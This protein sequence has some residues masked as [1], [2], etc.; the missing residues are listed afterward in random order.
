M[1]HSPSF[2]G[3]LGGVLLAGKAD[4]VNNED[5]LVG[6]DPV[7]DNPIQGCSIGEISMA[8]ENEPV[9]DANELAALKEVEVS[10]EMRN[11]IPIDPMNTGGSDGPAPRRGLRPA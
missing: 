6:D 9:E 3:N 5:G 2:V 7:E 4:E 10:M 1:G 8:A 11:R